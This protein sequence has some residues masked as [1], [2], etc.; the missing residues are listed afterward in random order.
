[1]KTRKK[2]IYN[3]MKHTYHAGLIAVVLTLLVSASVAAQPSQELNIDVCVYGATGS[4]ILAALA[5]KQR[6]F[7]V[8]VVEPSRWVG[9]ILGAGIKPI[10]DCPNFE[11]VGGMTRTLM[12]TLGMR[13]EPGDTTESG[14]RKAM[15]SMS[16][17]DI[18][19]DFMRILQD[20]KIQVIFQHRINRL[21]KD[22]PLVT[23]AYFDLAPFDETGCPPEAAQETDDLLVRAKIYID[24]G[25]DGDLMARAGVSYRVGRESTEDYGEEMAGVRDPTNLTPIDPYVVPGKPGSGLLPM[26][27]KPQGKS[28]GAGD[29]FTQAYN[30]R[31]YVT[32]DPAFSQPILKPDNYNSTDYELVGRYVKYLTETVQDSSALYQQLS[33]IFPGWLNSGE[34]NY[35]RNSL[36][37]MAP[38]GI[39][40]LYANGDYATQSRIWKYH[41]EYLMGLHYFLSTD[42]RVPKPFRDYVASLGLNGYHFPDTHG[43]PNQLYIRV[44]RRLV[45]NYTLT[46]HDVYNETTV[47]DPIGLAQYGLDTYPARRII[48]EKEGKTYVALEGKMFVGGAK[49]PTNVPYP[50]PYRAITPL[51]HECVNLLVPVCFSATHLGY[52]SARME[53]VFMICGQSAGLAAVQS[54]EEHKAVQDIDIKAFETS[55]KAA[56]QRLSWPIYKGV[57]K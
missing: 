4:G 20:N 1:M 33:W 42:S 10:Q 8:V 41:Q 27:Q 5:V 44:S 49:G 34:Y 43:W 21:S 16:P 30:F 28:V 48:V 31:F 2:I 3:N 55:L 39:S 26:I 15:E 38:V 50:I 18:R 40:H 23:G 25:Y 46:S 9:G 11:A 36:I 29:Y 51:K 53:P 22:G 37:T 52:A 57:R 47:N 12:K 19:E 6:G 45:G 13:E 24:A 7:S 35:Q 17:R 56:G 14:L 32:T 54:I